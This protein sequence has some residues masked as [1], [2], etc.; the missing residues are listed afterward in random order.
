MRIRLT[1]EYVNDDPNTT[2]DKE[3]EAWYSG[4]I[5]VKD[6]AKLIVGNSKVRLEDITPRS[7]PVNPA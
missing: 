1:F 4:D 6:I 2:I 7:D 3:Q 5:N